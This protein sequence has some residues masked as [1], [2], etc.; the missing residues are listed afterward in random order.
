MGA[1]RLAL[2]VLYEIRASE[3]GPFRFCGIFHPFAEPSDSLCALQCKHQ[4]LQALLAWLPSVGLVRFRMV[5]LLGS[6]LRLVVCEHVG[7]KYGLS[8]Y[9]ST[10]LFWSSI[11]YRA[12]V[13]DT[14]RVD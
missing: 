9:G 11:S 3:V 6:P 10:V 8:V 2:V 1:A 14:S 12:E 4:D 7:V 5:A 13:D